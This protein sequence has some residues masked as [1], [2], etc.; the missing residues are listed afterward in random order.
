MREAVLK[1]LAQASESN[2][3]DLSDIPNL[4]DLPHELF[5]LTSLKALNLN[6][7]HLRYLPDAFFKLENLEELDLTGSPSSLGLQQLPDQIARLKNLRRL[8]LSRNA[9]TTLPGAVC[10]LNQLEML[11]L[12]DNQLRDL[13]AEIGCLV[14]LKEL[15]L[16]GNQLRVLPES[17]GNMVQ[18]TGFFLQNNRLSFLP[19]SVGNLLKLER[20]NLNGNQLK[21]IPLTIRQLQR[22]EFFDLRDN[23]IAD[24]AEAFRHFSLPS[25]ILHHLQL[26][27]EAMEE[28]MEPLAEAKVVFL[29]DGNVG[30]TSLVNRLAFGH[31]NSGEST[32]RGVA[33][34]HWRVTGTAQSCQLNIW[35][36]AGQAIMHAT[37]QLFLSEHCIYVIVLNARQEM[38]SERLIYWLNVIMSFAGEQ[39]AILVVINGS[40]ENRL[41]LD[42][43]GLSKT[44]GIASF[45][46]T[47]AATEMGIASLRAH[48]VDLAWK[49]LQTTP[50][51]VKLSWK[52][53]RH[54]VSE[55]LNQLTL[56]QMTFAE[57]AEI[58]EAR[59]IYGQREREE[60]LDLLH[61]I[62]A[63]FSP[64]ATAENRYLLDPEDL[65]HNIYELQTSKEMVRSQVDNGRVSP[66]ALQKI[67]ADIQM[68]DAHWELLQK[69]MQKYALCLQLSDDDLIF[70]RLLP[71]EEPL[72]LLPDN[73]NVIRFTY[74]YNFLPES[75]LPRFIG[76][77]QELRLQTLIYEALW[78]RGVFLR[79]ESLHLLMKIEPGSR[80]L[81]LSLFGTES[82]A[83]N[84][85]LEEVRRVL[86]QVHDQ[87]AHLQVEQFIPVIDSSGRELFVPYEHLI[88]LQMA[89]HEKFIP[90]GGNEAIRVRDLLHLV[91]AR[92]WERRELRLAIAERF[93]LGELK[94]LCFDLDLDPDNLPDNQTTDGFSR[95]LI[96]FMERRGRMTELIIRC[97]QKRPNYT[98][99]PTI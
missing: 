98:D 59:Q 61:E 3:L 34:T 71:V 18:L 85:L 2:A 49:K 24:A 23:P 80:R 66:S 87:I 33:I 8:N 52:S 97:Q 79:V 1:R 47:S 84:H 29:G 54:R 30:K 4:D 83:A 5:S 94:N 90:Y 77:F 53:V 64:P 86:G 38:Q 16:A 68:E 73:A 15:F 39:A 9:L 56:T 95:E 12:N 44:Y 41:L 26:Q 6:G 70:T 92:H 57:F 13:P 60:L 67:L 69:L 93:N 75:V 21:Q 32:T 36:F 76:A 96:L 25:V 35:D 45:I 50:K 42:Q 31:F 55:R 22:L 63:V 20:F 10:H 99:W 19:A 28:H 7:H 91:E 65:T 78:Q 89:G 46:E 88:A 37:H 58:C 74:S 40:E 11:S 17:I 43:R 82:Q 14:Q 81:D 48:I 62:G 51:M 72:L 27:F